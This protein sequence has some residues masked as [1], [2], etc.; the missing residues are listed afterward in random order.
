MK[1]RSI[2]I[3]LFFNLFYLLWI[4]IIFKYS[5][6]SRSLEIIYPIILLVISNF[7]HFITFQKIKSSSSG[8]KNGTLLTIPYLLFFLIS[9]RFE[10]YGGIFGNLVELITLIFLLFLLGIIG[11]Y[12]FYNSSKFG[13]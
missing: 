6:P 8:L 13:E 3:I 4:Y 12:F 10:I 5:H 7:L 2:L 9:F 11:A 1:K